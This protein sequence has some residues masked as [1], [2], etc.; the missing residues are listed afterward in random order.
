MAVTGAVEVYSRTINW[1]VNQAAF[2]LFYS[3]AVSWLLF[4][5]MWSA[6]SAMTTDRKHLL[7]VASVPTAPVPAGLIPPFARDID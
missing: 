3:R 4:P 7:Q 2:T 6:V 5:E 1:A